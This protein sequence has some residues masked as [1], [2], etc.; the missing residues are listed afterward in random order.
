MAVSRNE[1]FLKLDSIYETVTEHLILIFTQPNSQ[2]FEHRSTEVVGMF[3][4][5]PKLKYRQNKYATAKNIRSVYLDTWFEYLDDRLHVHVDDAYEKEHQPTP[6]LSKEELDKLRTQLKSYLNFVVE[7]INPK[8][9]EVD[10]YLA[11]NKL[12]ELAEI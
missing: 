8:T 3:T 5:F 10:K 1:F 9:S 11:R 7:N 2:Y 12:K 6:Q 4:K